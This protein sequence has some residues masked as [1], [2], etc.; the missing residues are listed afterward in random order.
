MTSRSS[1][2]RRTGRA[3]LAG[4][5]PGILT[6][7]DCLRLSAAWDAFTKARDETDPRAAELSEAYAELSREIHGRLEA[8]KQ[9]R[10]SPP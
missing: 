1:R 10:V 2:R 7:R 8:E 3:T 9:W 5:G 6:I 4:F